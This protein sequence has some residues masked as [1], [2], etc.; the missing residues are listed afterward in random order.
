MQTVRSPG[1]D[2]TRLRHNDLCHIAANDTCIY[3]YIHIYIYI[4]ICER[5]HNA[6]LVILVYSFICTC[7]YMFFQINI[8]QI[9]DLLLFIVITYIVFLTEINGHFTDLNR[10][11]LPY[12][13][14]LSEDIPQQTWPYMV[15]YLH[16]TLLKFPQMRVTIPQC[17]FHRWYTWYK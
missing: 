16:L 7:N 3:I 4:Y 17:R 1:S 10:E 14:G 9:T 6:Y 8:V 12:I 13:K 5:K 2:G 11:Y 15:Q